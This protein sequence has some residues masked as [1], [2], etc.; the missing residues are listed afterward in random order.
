MSVHAATL[1][2]TVMDAQTGE[3]LNGIS[4]TVMSQAGTSIT[5]SDADGM[6]EIADLAAGVYTISASAPGYAD[7]TMANVELVA[8]G[9]TLGRNYA[10]FRGYRTGPSFRFG[11]TSS[12]KGA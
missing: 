11:I 4:V 2:V 6:L 3:K 1:N 12:R 9:T 10:L 7:K 8:D 5:A